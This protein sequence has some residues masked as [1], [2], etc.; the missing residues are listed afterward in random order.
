MTCA[1]GTCSVKKSA[2][3]AMINAD[4]DEASMHIKELS[5]RS[6]LTRMGLLLGLLGSISFLSSCATPVG[7]VAAWPVTNAEQ[8]AVTGTV[9]DVLCELSGN[10]A[11]NCGEGKRQL[12]IKT[13]INGTV[14]VSKNLT[15]Y[16]GAAD[17]L[18]PFCG[19]MVEVNGL[20]TDHKDVRFF[21]AQNIRKPG[22]QWQQTTGYLQAWSNRSGQPTSL[23][24]DW[25][26]HDA[27]VKAIIER[28]G[29][30]GLGPEADNEYFK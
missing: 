29:R 10:C 1:N 13:E 22:G 2:N 27:R 26:Y 9:V 14:L 21:Q 18:W 8:S 17:D 6:T 30:L 4:T 7:E 5:V 23:A 25:Q 12:A 11:D 24:K 16:S 20:F 15:N 3:S 28:D 19:E